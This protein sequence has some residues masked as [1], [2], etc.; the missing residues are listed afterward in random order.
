M[1]LLQVRKQLLSFVVCGGGPTGV[2]V[3]AELHDMIQ[4][5]LSKLYPDLMEDTK[6]YYLL[7]AE[8][9]RI[10]RMLCQYVRWPM[11]T[12]CLGLAGICNSSGQWSGA[13]LHMMLVLVYDCLHCAK[14]PNH[15]GGYTICHTP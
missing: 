2:E 10:L 5:D 14:L 4:E 8:L 11:D 6:V 3:A 15:C 7:C 9:S 13:Q 12:T 1:D